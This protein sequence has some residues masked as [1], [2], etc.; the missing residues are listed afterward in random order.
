MATKMV[1][2][3]DDALNGGNV[4]VHWLSSN[5]HPLRLLLPG[6][7]GSGQ[8]VLVLQLPHLIEEQSGSIECLLPG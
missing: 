8:V 6:S 3:C 7:K 2:I 5:C 4:D 1:A